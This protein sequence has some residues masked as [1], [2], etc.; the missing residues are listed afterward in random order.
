[1]TAEAAA[2]LIHSAST[3]A[4]LDGL[5]PE[6]LLTVS[7]WADRHRML[8]N[9]AS[10]EPGR[11][12]TSRTPYLREIMDCLSPSTDVEEVVFIKGAQVGGTEAGNNWIGYVIDYAP[13]PMMAVQPTVEMAKR[14]SKQRIA[15]LIE[16]CPR[17]KEKVS[18]SKTRD[19]SNTILSKEFPGGVLVMTG[20]NSAVGLRSLPARYLFL[21]EVDGYPEDVDGEGDPVF[22]AR[23][24]TRT[25]A[26]RKILAVSTPTIAGRSRIEQLWEDSDR[27]R[28]HVPC[29][30]C[31]QLQWLKWGQVSWPEGKPELAV[32]VCEHCKGEIK[33]HQKTWMLENGKWIAENPGIRNGKVAGFHLNSLYSPVGWFS[34]GDAADLFLK[35]KGKPALLRGFINTV[36]GETWAE[37]GDA[38]D[39]QRL[40]DR[41]EAYPL[42]KVPPEV[43]FLTAGCD[44]QKDRIEI[45]VCGWGRDKQTWSIDHRVIMGDTA[46]G[47]P[48]TELN[49]IL[50]ETW[51]GEHGV[52]F[53]IRMLAVDSGYNTQHV[54]NWA[55]KHPMTRVMAVKG[56]DTSSVALGLPSTVDVTVGGKKIKRGFKVWPV[57]VS[58]LKSELYSWL[59]LDKPIDGDS[60]PHGYCHFPQYGDEYFKQLT[61]EQVVARVVRGFRKYEFEKLRDR[62][63]AL[64][65][66]VYN[67]A[68]AIAVGIDRFTEAQWQQFNISK[69][70]PASPGMQQPTA[71]KKSTPSAAAPRKSN[72]W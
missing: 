44:V 64:D 24:R 51:E 12:R 49:G 8:S 28:Y 58:I 54:Y 20:A 57:G 68:A 48:W 17:I 71:Q 43:Y 35:A 52:Q 41:R 37:R 21:D 60:Y 65:M 26:R 4:I 30:H 2:A 15:P 27:R 13:G 53:H 56:V 67:R 38:P 66:R 7:E 5:E 69:P 50:S 47:G 10:A 9:K 29:P 32:Y 1:M 55:R 45:E 6:P 42:N 16:E 34:W 72:Y 39:W 59:R 14:N 70:V 63:E 11:W 36:L 46:T 23:A 22:L 19:S 3:Q 31:N 18:D 40:Y 62:N 33:E 25:Y 61:A